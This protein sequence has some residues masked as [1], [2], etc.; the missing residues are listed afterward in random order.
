MGLSFFQPEGLSLEGWLSIRLLIVMALL[1]MSEALPLAVTA[2]LPLLIFPFYKVNLEDIYSAYANPLI[3]LF[4]GGFILGAALEVSKAH[5]WI[6]YKISKGFSKSKTP[7]LGLILSAA[8]L[9][10]WI[11]NTAA[12]L[13][14]IPIVL[15][16]TQNRSAGY[17]KA[18][19]FGTMYACTIGGYFT[20]IGTPPNAVY[21]A[22]M[23]EYANRTVTFT[24]WIKLGAPLGF[25]LLAFLYFYLRTKFKI[26]Q[27]LAFPNRELSPSGKKVLVVFLLTAF[28]WVFLD[29]P[30]QVVALA[31]AGVLMTLNTWDPL[32]LGKN[33]FSKVPLAILLLF[34]GGLSLSKGLMV[35]GAGAWLAQ[36]FFENLDSGFLSTSIGVLF[37]TLL[38]E[39]GSNTASANLLGP[40]AISAAKNSGI[41]IGEFLFPI[42]MGCNLGFMLPIAT[43]PNAIAYATGKIT[44][45]EMICYGFLLDLIGVAALLCL[46]PIYRYFNWF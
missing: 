29:L 18:M 1:W 33:P 12:C 34:G 41:E 22:L 46:V 45:K 16:L 17:T 19:I 32:I 13:M 8:F 39:V 30:H 44:I 6:A 23:L 38:S 27:A 10:M 42:I 9:S 3:F 26:T 11:S 14:F 36:T 28:C 24:D 37:A 20:L 2:L 21:A 25:I 40:I 31:S 15:S 7:L 5:E 4:L 35:T 43:P